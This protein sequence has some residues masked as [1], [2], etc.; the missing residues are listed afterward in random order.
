[1]AAHD[2]TLPDPTTCVIAGCG[3][4]GAMLGLLLA[5]AGVDVVVLEKHPDFFRDFRGDTVHASTLQILDDLDLTEAFARVPQQRTTRI[6]LMT[7]DGMT[8]MGDFTELPGRFR[9]LSMV[10]QWDFLSFLTAEAAR[11][12]GFSLHRE[13]EVTGWSRTATGWSAGCAAA[14]PPGRR[15]SARTWWSPPTGGRPPPAPRPVW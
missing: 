9:Y 4:A 3:P 8:A 11:Y 14:P 5:R 15:R 10:P 6:N 12:P 1:M 2:R 13:V 7:D